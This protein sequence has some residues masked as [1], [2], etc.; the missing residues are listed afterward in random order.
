MRITHL[1]RK[2]EDKINIWPHFVVSSDDHDFFSRKPFFA[3]GNELLIIVSEI[4]THIHLYRYL[5]LM[6]AYL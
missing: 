5:R 6:L 3:I 4:H 2:D 1:E